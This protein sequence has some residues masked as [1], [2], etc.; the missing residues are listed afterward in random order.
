VSA[1]A[2]ADVANLNAQLDTFDKKRFSVDSDYE[3]AAARFPHLAKQVDEE[4]NEHDWLNEKKY[5]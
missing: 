1:A 4:L 2:Q 5:D 3:A